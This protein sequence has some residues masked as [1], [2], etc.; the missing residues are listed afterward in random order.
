M[1]KELSLHGFLYLENQMNKTRN[2][3]AIFSYTKLS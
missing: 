2:N 1:L 3:N